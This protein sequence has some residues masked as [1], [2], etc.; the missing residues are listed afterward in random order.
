MEI[1]RVALESVMIHLRGTFRYSKLDPGSRKRW[2]Y[3]ALGRQDG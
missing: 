1:P 3:Q 2:G